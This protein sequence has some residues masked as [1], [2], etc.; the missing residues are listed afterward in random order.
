M[1]YS[2]H[3]SGCVLV[4]DAMPWMDPSKPD[5]VYPWRENQNVTK[6]GNKVVL[7]GT[8]TL[9]GS[10]VPISDCVTNLA[11]YANVPLHT[12]AMCASGNPAKMLGLESVKGFFKAGCDA[13]LVVLDRITGRVKQTW[14]AGKLVWKAK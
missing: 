11:R 7:E 2:S 5:G 14:V 3:P 9:A 13:D 4:S 12:A 1:A 6:T 8:D 10:V